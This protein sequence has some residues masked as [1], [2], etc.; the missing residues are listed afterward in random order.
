MPV[1]SSSAGVNRIRSVRNS[2][3]SPQTDIDR[4]SGKSLRDIEEVKRRKVVF[5]FR[6]FRFV[7]INIV[8]CFNNHYKDEKDYFQKATN[9][10]ADAL[11][12]FSNETVI[13]LTTNRGKKGLFH[14][15]QIDDKRDIIERILKEYKFSDQR[16]NDIIVGNNLWQFTS[17]LNCPIR[18]IVEM[19]DNLISF[20]FIDTNH[21]IYLFRD[22]TEESGSFNFEYCPVYRSEKCEIFKYSDTCYAL[23]FLDEKK[24]L[25][26]LSYDYAPPK[27]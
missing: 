4:A 25:E 5:S 19:S 7:P 10:I 3:P 14:F 9:F 2:L 22:K 18:L 23:E 20:L 12:L 6:D 13:D 21:H 27:D 24:L 26:S 11:P 16:I 17:E 8:D 15:H 1:N